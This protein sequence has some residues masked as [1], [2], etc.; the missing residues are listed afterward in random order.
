MIEHKLSECILNESQIIMNHSCKRKEVPVD[1]SLMKNLKSFI[2]DLSKSLEILPDFLVNVY[3]K[4][5]ID[6]LIERV[7]KMVTI[8][9]LP[10]AYRFF[11]KTKED[12]IFGDN[13]YQPNFEI[14][15]DFL[16]NF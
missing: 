1:C 3:S 12:I 6:L 9:V 11:A 4:E 13:S 5:E 16:K 7:D 15:T 10:D 2:A 14:L 8:T